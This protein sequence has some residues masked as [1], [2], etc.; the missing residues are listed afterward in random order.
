MVAT[1]GVTLPDSTNLLPACPCLLLLEAPPLESGKGS[2]K[3][4]V[5]GMVPMFVTLKAPLALPFTGQC[6]N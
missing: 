1:R 5:M 3:A 6:P 2:A 4:T